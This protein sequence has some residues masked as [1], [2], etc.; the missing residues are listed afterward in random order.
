MFIECRHNLPHAIVCLHHKV[1]VDVEPA[2]AKPFLSRHNRSMRR[3]VR[4]IEKERCLLFGRSCFDILHGFTSQPWQ[5]VYLIFV[6]D[7]G[8]VFDHPLHITRMMEAVEII[9]TTFN[10]SIWNFTSNGRERFPPFALN[11]LSSRG[12]GILKVEM[13][14]TD[15]ARVVA[16]CFEKT[17]DSGTVFS[18]EIWL[19]PL[20]DAALESR[21]PTVTTS[22]QTVSRR[23]TNRGTRVCIGKDHPFRG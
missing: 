23:R 14:L 1:R 21:P 9:K 3:T 22:H 11:N 5:H 16:L 4:H 6:H 13:P 2:F 8:I 7:H 10:R 20:H 18:D 17:R 12:I 15:D 19:K